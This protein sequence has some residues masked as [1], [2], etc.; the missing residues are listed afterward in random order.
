[1]YEGKAAARRMRLQ[2][3]YCRFTLL[4]ICASLVVFGRRAPREGRSQTSQYSSALQFPSNL[5]DAYCFS[6]QDSLLSTVPS[7]PPSNASDGPPEAKR[8]RSDISDDSIASAD[9][10]VGQFS[11][12]LGS[13]ATPEML[14][15]LECPVSDPSA[16]KAAQQQDQQSDNVFASDPVNFLNPL[17]SVAGSTLSP[18]GML[19]S[20]SERLVKRQKGNNGLPVL[21]INYDEVLDS[22]GASFLAQYFTPLKY[23][24]SKAF[25][26][27]R[28]GG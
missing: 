24:S 15:M 27:F 22:D 13:C 6:R 2:G 3:R 14:D 10:L 5:P 16:N 19:A 26:F 1:M 7:A 18:M 11:P 20:A 23:A 17:P 28:N 25:S 4:A 8:P 12:F 9:T 21:S